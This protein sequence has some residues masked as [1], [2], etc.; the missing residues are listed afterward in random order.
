MDL[1]RQLVLRHPQLAGDDRVGRAIRIIH[2]HQ[3]QRIV[4][5]TFEVRSTSRDKR[6]LISLLKPEC[7]CEDWAKGHICK[8]LIACMLYN[9]M[10]G[11][12]FPD[13]LPKPPS[14]PLPEQSRITWNPV[15]W[16]RAQLAG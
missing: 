7:Q 13:V 1:S 8:H 14:S 12:D 9:V 4:G 11:N 6:Y 2:Q 16:A 15:A 3:V 10:D 5:S